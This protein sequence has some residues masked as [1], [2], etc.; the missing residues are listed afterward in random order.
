MNTLFSIIVSIISAV[1][2]VVPNDNHLVNIAEAKTNSLASSV[3]SIVDIPH[4][5][6]NSLPYEFEGEKV[7]MDEGEVKSTALLNPVRENVEDIKDLIRQTFP[8]DPIMLGVAKCESNTT[9]YENGKTLIG[10]TTPDFGVFQINEIWIPMA[11][12][13]NLDIM[14][15]EDNIK[16]ARYIYDTQKLNAWSASASCWLKNL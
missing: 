3:L 11:E 6:E 14:I 12:K 1:A 8:K 16:M 4:P 13:M 5:P 9:H 7:E 2:P 10:R 15:L